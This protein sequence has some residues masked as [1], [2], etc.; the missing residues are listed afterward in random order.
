[1]Q[2]HYFFGIDGGGT[3]SRIALCDKDM[4]IIYQGMGGSTNIYSTSI[5]K[6]ESHLKDII[7][8]VIDETHITSFT[9]GCI[10]SAGLSRP[11]EK[12]LFKKFFHKIL[13]NTPIKLCNDGEI[14]LVGSLMEKEGYA[15]I[16]G[17]GSLAL[18]RTESGEIYRSGGYGYM[19]GDEG[20][21]WWIGAE[22][23]KRTL[24]SFDKRDFSTSMTNDLLQGC[25]LD[26][27]EDLVEYVHH[28]ATK[29]DIAKLAPIVTMYARQKDPLALDILNKG[30]YELFLLVKSVQQT[31]ITNN[32]IVLAGGVFEHDE[33]IKA[34]FTRLLGTFLPYLE[35]IP[36]R[37]SALTG[38]LLLA[39]SETI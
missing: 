25:N 28:K 6:V 21:A 7:Q 13:P 19:L 37:G 33:I 24:R 11:K 3:H 29:A 36:P 23:I 18:A 2:T 26:L 10:G 17:T 30:A 38:A 8:N 27:L 34:E 16:S 12:A 1:M 32:K 5:E 14:L 9:G 22:A 20:S 31:I 4:N 15:I 35:I 39:I